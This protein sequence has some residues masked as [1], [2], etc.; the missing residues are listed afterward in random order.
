M[1]SQSLVGIGFVLLVTL[2]S[3][4]CSSDGSETEIGDSR[5][6]SVVKVPG[7]GGRSKELPF[8]TSFSRRWNSANDGSDY[9]PCTALGADDLVALG[10]DPGSAK[11]GAGTDGQTARGCEWRYRGTSPGDHWTVSQIVGNSPSLAQ[12]KRRISGSAD[13]WLPDLTI[14]GRPVGIHFVK[15]G[16]DCDTYVQ[17]GRAAVST[18][19][20]TLDT[21]VPVRE[22]CD[23]AIAFTKATIDKIP[24]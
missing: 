13:V 23:R 7:V 21:S 4:S 15:S 14:G 3:A 11:D 19:V 12:E 22:I 17:S 6:S 8:D 9:E 1:T 20:V 16:G 18:I 2:A 5:A 24:H 10:I